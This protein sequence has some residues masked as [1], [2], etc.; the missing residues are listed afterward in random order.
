[1]H[2]L[3][4]QIHPS[5]RTAFF[6]WFVG[7]CALY[8]AWHATGG[9]PLSVS[10]SGG[11]LAGAIGTIVELLN[12][13]VSSVAHA[14][15]WMRFVLNEVAVFVGLVSLYRFVRR[16]GMPQ[17]A[18]RAVWLAACSPLMVLTLPGSDWAFV[19]AAAMASLALASASMVG[20]ASL[21]YLSIGVTRPEM[22]VLWPGF[23]AVC[24]GARG[25][26]DPVAWMAASVPL[27][28]FAGRVLWSV[29]V[30]DPK[31]LYAYE[32]T[33]RTGFE[34][35]GLVHHLPD[36][37]VIAACLLGIG[38]AIRLAKT[39]PASWLIMSVPC[40]IWPML[41]E[42]STSAIGTMLVCAAVFG[43]LG[44]FTEDPSRE[45]ILLTLSLVGCVAMVLI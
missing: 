37:G 33:W 4:A 18:D 31:S 19:F 7:R 9:D 3:V 8:V 39:R 5:F 15:D 43:H 29:L 41:H 45:R 40:M 13:H 27:L 22:L 2:P 42:P 36:L 28:A 30:G 44:R 24:I 17:A 11:A 20:W 16:D 34:W 10:V 23:A 26:G 38:L 6:A 35:Q 1:M 21:V 25:K 32:A 14:G 12:T